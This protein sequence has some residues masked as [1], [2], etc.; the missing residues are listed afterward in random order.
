MLWVPIILWGSGTDSRRTDADYGWTAEPA[1]NSIHIK[2]TK[3]LASVLHI[4]CT[5]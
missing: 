2:P 4:V 3:Y 1:G 5:Q